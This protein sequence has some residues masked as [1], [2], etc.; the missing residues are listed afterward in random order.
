MSWSPERKKQL[1]DLIAE[2]R[3]FSQIAAIMGGVTR[4]AC[5]G[6]AHRL[7]IATEGGV[8]AT[9]L[10]KAGQVVIARPLRPKATPKRRVAKATGASTA[11]AVRRAFLPGR[12]V[13]NDRWFCQYFTGP[14]LTD[15]DKCGKPRV[16]IEGP[17]GIDRDGSYCAEHHALCTQGRPAMKLNGG[18]KLATALRAVRW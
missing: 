1:A 11:V 2:G 10:E 18:D 6:M 4:N 8:T 16:V 17:G 3:T 14:G 7:G 5:I 13:E 15:E 12:P 9:R